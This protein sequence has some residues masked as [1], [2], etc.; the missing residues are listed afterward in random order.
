MSWCRIVGGTVQA[1]TLNGVDLDPAELA[2]LG[3]V[4]DANTRADWDATLAVN[5]DGVYNMVTGMLGGTIDLASTPEQ[6]TTVTIKVPRRAP[7]R[8]AQSGS[9]NLLAL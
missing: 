3:K 5:L 8:D 2:A 1:I 4:E 9:M 6:G 7:K